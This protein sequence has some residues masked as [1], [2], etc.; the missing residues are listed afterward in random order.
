MM[1]VVGQATLREGTSTGAEYEYFWTGRRT[2]P[3]TEQRYSDC[4]SPVSRPIAGLL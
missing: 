2:M 3:R 1:Q 4:Y